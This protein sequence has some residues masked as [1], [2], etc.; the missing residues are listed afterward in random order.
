SF[1]ILALDHDLQIASGTIGTISVKDPQG[2]KVAIWDQVSFDKGVLAY[3]LP[4]S[5]YALTGRW[6][7]T[8]EV[9]QSQFFCTYEVAPGIG[10]GQPDISVAEE[11]YV[12]LKFGTEMRRRYKPGLPFS[13]KVSI[14]KFR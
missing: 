9:E 5:P 1:W 10:I 2:T 7:I 12:E 6:T 13:G 11:H 14:K 4:L 8:V 3:T